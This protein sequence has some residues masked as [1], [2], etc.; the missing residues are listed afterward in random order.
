M[1]DEGSGVTDSLIQSTPPIPKDAKGP[2]SDSED[3]G[4]R[5]AEVELPHTEDGNGE[6]KETNLTAHVAG[7]KD[8]PAPAQNGGS[9]FVIKESESYDARDNSAV[10][11]P[12]SSF[13]NSKGRDFVKGPEE[14][15]RRKSSLDSRKN[16]PE[17]VLLRPRNDVMDSH[18]KQSSVVMENSK[19]L[20]E[21]GC[22]HRFFL[23]PSY[24]LRRQMLL[25]FGSV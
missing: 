6:I 24:P 10:S 17:S 23:N 18:S 7:Q 19:R 9:L 16:I 22:F 12:P 15:D 3:R 20:A 14:E 5:L 1:V 2:N 11:F 8:R 21:Q 25:T 4:T 13:D